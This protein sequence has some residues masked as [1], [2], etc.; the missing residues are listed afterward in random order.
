[1][2]KLNII[3]REMA[4]TYK[5]EIL[6]GLRR[7][8]IFC[9]PTG[10]GKTGF[11]RAIFNLH[12]KNF[13][14]GIGYGVAFFLTPRIGLTDQ[15]AMALKNFKIID[16][17]YPDCEL[18]TI[19]IHSDSDDDSTRDGL[20]AAIA[21]FHREGKYVIIAA[22]YQSTRYLFN[23]NADVAFCD[24]AHHLV[25]QKMHN[26][27]MYG[28][29][30]NLPRVFATATPKSVSGQNTE[31]FNNTELYGDYL[32]A[33]TPKRAIDERLIV[34]A[35]LHIINA[36]SREHTDAETVIS[37]VSNIFSTHKEFNKELPAKVLFAM[38]G[39]H[40]VQVVNQYWEELHFR[41]GATI[42]T[43]TAEDGAHING[44]KVSRDK[45]LWEINNNNGYAIVAHMHILTEGI[46]V[47]VFTGSVIMRD[48]DG[49]VIVQT[50]GRTLRVLSQ[51][52]DENGLAK[53]IEHRIKKTALVTVL[54]YNENTSIVE[55]VK[56]IANA[57]LSAGFE[58]Y[59]HDV[60]FGGNYANKTAETT[61]GS[62]DGDDGEDWID[63]LQFELDM[64]KNEYEFNSQYDLVFNGF[65][66]TN[67]PFY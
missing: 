54:V 42:F 9:A 46:D 1:M 47:D 56:P 7:R 35:Q 57:L 32:A 34:P 44:I 22:T 19:T 27:V 17:E 61:T 59:I 13:R 3:Q 40:M 37:Q 66:S 2:K 21:E 50:I 4:K 14:S 53:P 6:N 36:Y 43:I 58:Y 28:L 41:T 23:I 33:I 8:G 11:A 49:P 64:V 62:M 48:M 63:E 24:E 65:I 60:L 38:K 5:D 31:G 15:Q 51:D 16:N 10:T 29:D 26:T 52:R 25:S 30:V 67:N 18:A 45:F 39:G 20:R 12:A 55:Q